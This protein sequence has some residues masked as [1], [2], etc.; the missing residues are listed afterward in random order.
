MDFDWGDFCAIRKVY[1]C[2]IGKKGVVLK[3]QI[4]TPPK[5]VFD[6]SKCSDKGLNLNLPN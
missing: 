2:R 5:N 6:A 1:V 3:R 4:F